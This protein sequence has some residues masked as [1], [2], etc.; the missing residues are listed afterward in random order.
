MLSK[1]SNPDCPAV[2]LYLHR[3]KL[4]KLET[5]ANPNGSDTKRKLE[6]FWL[7]ASCCQSMTLTYDRAAG[8][9]TRRTLK[10]AVV[11]AS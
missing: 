7:C 8:I 5:G 3:G 1:C 4:F 11:S 10:A 6:Y 2:F 9:S